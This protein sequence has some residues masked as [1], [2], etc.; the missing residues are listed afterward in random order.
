MGFFLTEGF[1]SVN[2]VLPQCTLRLESL[3][4]VSPSFLF[5]MLLSSII[6]IQQH[7]YQSTAVTSSSNALEMDPSPAPQ[8]PD[9]ILNINSGFRNFDPTRNRDRRYLPF[10]ISCDMSDHNG[11]IGIMEGHLVNRE[12]AVQAG[13]GRTMEEVDTECSLTMASMIFDEYGQLQ[14]KWFLGT[15]KGSGTWD[16]RINIG[17]FFM[18]DSVEVRERYRRR[19]FARYLVSELLYQM[20][21]FRLN[22]S[23]VFTYVG[24]LQG[25]ARIDAIA[26]WRAMGFKRIGLSHAFCFAMSMDDKSKM[27]DAEIEDA[28][29][30]IYDSEASYSTEPEFPSAEESLEDES[31]PQSLTS[32]ELNEPDEPQLPPSDDDN[33]SENSNSPSPPVDEEA[34]LAEFFSPSD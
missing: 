27:P 33:A 11:N 31:S 9:F 12:L 34:P 7:N 16:A 22:V 26:F 6:S 10:E 29:R 8:N 2:T 17:N 28:E 1:L 3:F 32:G 21:A 23:Y 25:A 4:T 5:A 24:E 19:G 18:I 15:R 30:D 14:Q 13:F 20:R